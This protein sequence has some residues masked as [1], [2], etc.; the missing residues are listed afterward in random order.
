MIYCE[1]IKKQKY[2]LNEEVPWQEVLDI[3]DWFQEISLDQAQRTIRLGYPMEGDGS[4]RNLRAACACSKSLR[5]FLR[6]R[7]TKLDRRAAELLESLEE[8]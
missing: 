8:A 6:R 2:R 1:V 5:H 7:E 3:L 4:L